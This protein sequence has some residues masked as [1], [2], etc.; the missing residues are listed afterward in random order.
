[1][2]GG[3]IDPALSAALGQDVTS[4]AVPASGTT[5]ADFAAMAGAL[6]PTDEGRARSLAPATDTWSFDG[7]YALPLSDQIGASINAKYSITNTAAL[8]GLSSGT[9][10]VPAGGASP[11]AAPVLLTR[12]YGVLGNDSHAE[13]AHI[14]ASTDGRFGRWRW[15]VTG[16]FDQAESRTTTDRGVDYAVLQAAINAGT[17]P[18]VANP[19]AII[20][21]LQP[22]TTAQKTR[23]GDANAT[24]NGP[25]F[26]LPAGRVRTTMQLGFE[27]IDLDA[28]SDRAGII[29]LTDLGRSSWTGSANIDVPLT[30]RDSHVLSAIGTLSA[31]GRFAYRDVSD[32]GGLK[33]WTVG[34]TW[35]PVERVDVIASWIGEENA[36]T[37]AQLGAAAIATPL[38]TLYDFTRGQ[39]VLATVLTGGNSAL[40]A[41]RR[42]DFKLSANW[43]P[44]ADTDWLLT[45][46]YARTRSQNTTADFPTLTPEIEAAFPGRVVRDVDGHIVSVDQRAV[47]FAATDGRQIRYGISYARSFGTPARG[48]MAGL[49]G[50]ARPGGP[51][52]GGGAGGGGAMGGGGG[53]G[54][55]PGMFGPP[56]GGGGRWSVAAYHTIILQ[57]DVLIR[58]GVP[59]LDRLNGSATGSSGGTSRH[60]VEFDGGWTNKGIGL[61]ANGTWSSSTTV[62]GGPV[63]GGGTASDLYFSPLLTVNLRL[64][65]DLNQ[66]RALVRSFGFF[67]NSRVRLSIDNLLADVRDVHDSTGATPL[68]YQPAYI[69]PYGRVFE[70]SFRKQF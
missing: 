23:T 9:V 35:S 18:F 39:T 14:G 68:R 37:V 48:P 41:E 24:L 15:T 3:A 55:G 49:M 58:A 19:A 5:L 11:F 47:N 34:G 42:R 38:V 61:R 43:R 32:F 2:G 27:R 69:D 26:M 60:Q 40:L 31:N 66:R 54:R 70:I 56:G 25:L 63:A 67:R 46:T 50:G 10:T 59:V 30:D 36:P 52:P 62:V 33:S 53:G 13:T 65:V 16:N 29:T 1:P 51:P 44:L 45:A 17:N 22:D 64:F 28:Q 12:A 57:D 20:T 7:T 6:F 8:L 4:I 21:L